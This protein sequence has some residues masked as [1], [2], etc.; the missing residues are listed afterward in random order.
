MGAGHKG[1]SAFLVALVIE[2][3]ALCVVCG[4]L[5]LGAFFYAS[6]LGGDLF[7]G[8]GTG[9]PSAHSYSW[10][11]LSTCSSY[12][13]Y[14]LIDNNNRAFDKDPNQL[15]TNYCSEGWYSYLGLVADF[16]VS[17]QIIMLVA[18]GVAYLRGGGTGKSV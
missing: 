9:G 14:F 18:T 2:F 11:A 8:L 17:L 15:Y 4:G 16:V 13:D 10:I 1:G 5:G 12:Y 7:F 3:F 6:N